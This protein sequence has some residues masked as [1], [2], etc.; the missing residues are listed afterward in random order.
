[1]LED[2]LCSRRAVRTLPPRSPA[3]SVG[4]RTCAKE[5]SVKRLKFRYIGVNSSN[6]FCQKNHVL[7]EA[8]K[9]KILEDQAHH[10]VGSGG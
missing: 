3:G 1:M 6:T 9:V 10:K 4:T 2:P 8:L 5:T 7:M